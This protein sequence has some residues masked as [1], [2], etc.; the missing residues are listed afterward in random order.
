MNPFETAEFKAALEGA[1]VDA[2]KK[3]GIRNFKR[4]S[5]FASNEMTAQDM[6]QAA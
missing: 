2:I 5:W 4:M 3:V 6:K 1:I